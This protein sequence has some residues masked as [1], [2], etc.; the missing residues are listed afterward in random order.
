MRTA[1]S[2]QESVP[3]SLLRDAHENTP[4]RDHHILQV[5][6]RWHGSLRVGLQY[7]YRL[8]KPIKSSVT[9]IES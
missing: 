3:V 5:V 9:C 4:Q 1:H 8:M 2:H 7:M 6:G